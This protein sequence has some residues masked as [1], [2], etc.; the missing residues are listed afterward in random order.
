[1]V[2]KNELINRISDLLDE[3]VPDDDAAIIGVALNRLALPEGFTV[4]ALQALAG[5]SKNR[6]ALLSYLKDLVNT[7]PISQASD[8]S[9]QGLPQD[10]MM[11]IVLSALRRHKLEEEAESRAKLSIVPS[12]VSWS[13]MNEAATRLNHPLV[14]GYAFRSVEKH[15]QPRVQPFAW[16]TPAGKEDEAAGYEGAVSW[17]QEHVCPAGVKVVLVDKATWLKWKDESRKLYLK[18]GKTD[19]V[20]V[21]D[22]WASELERPGV[23]PTHVLLGLAGMFELK[24]S[25]FCKEKSC[26][27][28]AQAGVEHLSACFMLDQALGTYPAQGHRFVTGVTDLSHFWGLFRMEANLMCLVQN[29][30]LEFPRESQEFLACAVMQAKAYLEEAAT[31][32]RSL[33]QKMSRVPG[34]Q[35]AD[36]EPPPAEPP[37][38]P[39]AGGTQPPLGGAHSG[40][41]Q[42]QQQDASSSSSSSSNNNSE[43]QGSS[44]CLSRQV[45][46]RVKAL[47]AQALLDDDA[48]RVAGAAHS[49]ALAAFLGHPLG[50]EGLLG[51]QEPPDYI[52]HPHLSELAEHPLWQHSHLVREAAMNTTG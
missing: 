6:V 14:A 41:S 10:K 22:E 34:D 39:S 26:A 12:S 9:A 30:P 1:M 40:H 29:P 3:N 51:L 7:P 4:E 20:F 5:A 23:T 50:F 35:G 38:E 45:I 42:Q 47:A 36:E 28:L 31:Q 19:V 48:A 2:T 11:E 25:T 24:T 32:L 33:Y 18:P 21:L 15:K 37:Q 27:A 43:V 49:A 17:L 52:S 44:M 8:Q 13:A 16:P 46:A